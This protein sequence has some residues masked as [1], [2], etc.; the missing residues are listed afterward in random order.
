M[1]RQIETAEISIKKV[2]AATIDMA[3]RLSY[4]DQNSMAKEIKFS[5][6]L[7]VSFAN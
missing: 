4:P 2:P 1:L 7:N 6:T 5:Q 3:F